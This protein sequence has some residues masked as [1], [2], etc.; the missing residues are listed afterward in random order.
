MN[1]SEYASG[2][3]AYIHFWKNHRWYRELSRMY[4]GGLIGGVEIYLNGNLIGRINGITNTYT[5]EDEFKKSAV[6]Y[7]KNGDNVL[8]IKTRQ[9]WRWGGRNMWA[10]NGGFDFNLDARLTN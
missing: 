10:Y 3:E 6:R 7:L 4:D 8:V 5:M 2:E 9:N 1:G